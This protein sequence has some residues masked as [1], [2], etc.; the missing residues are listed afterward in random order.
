MLTTVLLK[1][2]EDWWNVPNAILEDNTLPDM[3]MIAVKEGLEKTKEQ[4]RD[5]YVSGRRK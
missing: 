5:R 4:V 3:T 1:N 2:G